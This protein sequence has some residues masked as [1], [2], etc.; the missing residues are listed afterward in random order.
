MYFEDF[1]MY[2][3]FLKFKR[4]QE[5]TNMTNVEVSN[6]ADI[7][8]NDVDNVPKH[9]TQVDEAMSVID[10]NVTQLKHHLD[11]EKNKN[12]EGD[13]EQ[14]KICATFT[15]MASSRRRKTCREVYW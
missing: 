12:D 5:K 4:L 8:K 11:G 14:R 6:N 13:E 9:N 1:Q 3:E 2:Q 15:I 7:S 10:E